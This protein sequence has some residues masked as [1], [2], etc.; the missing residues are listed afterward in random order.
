M[1]VCPTVITEG[2]LTADFCFKHQEHLSTT[3]VCIQN[4]VKSVKTAPFL[5]NFTFY[6]GLF[7]QAVTENPVW[8][9]APGQQ[10]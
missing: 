3:A 1:M 8:L 10:W 9:L 7:N 2:Q 4:C 5:Q 6:S